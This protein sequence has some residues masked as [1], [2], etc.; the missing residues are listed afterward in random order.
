MVSIAIELKLCSSEEI[1]TYLKGIDETLLCYRV[2]AR[3][4]ATM[5]P[6]PDIV[7]EMKDTMADI[8]RGKMMKNSTYNR[9]QLRVLHPM[10][11]L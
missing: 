3:G 6:Q 10:V 8:L 9:D 2:E 1:E 5:V 11:T 7:T 4:T